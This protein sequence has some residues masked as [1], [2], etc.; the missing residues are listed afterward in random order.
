MQLGSLLQYADE[1]RA[2]AGRLVLVSGEAGVGK[3]SLLEELQHRL[4]EAT[5]AWGAC[6]G[7]FTPRP[8]APL[9][10]IARELGGHLLDLVR[11][12]AGRDELF[13]AL[14]QC[15]AAVDG[16][17]VL[18]VEDVQWADDA[19]LDLLRFLA[20]R[21]RR[22]PVPLVG[23]VRDDALAPTHRLRVALG[24]LAGQPFP[25]RID[26]PPLTEAGV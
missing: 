6:D 17:A 15:A 10:D 19:S 22:L 13:D 11:A 25:R 16:L 7:L 1:A 3:T 5:R 8:L 4:P 24:E 14:L 12:S 9:H 23:T 26:L 21:L 18:V 2:R 20:R